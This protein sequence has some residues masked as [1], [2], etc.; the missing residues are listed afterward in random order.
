MHTDNH[1]Q[2]KTSEQPTQRNES[3][4]S[5]E[6]AVRLSVL[7]PENTTFGWES[8]SF[9][10]CV[11][12][13]KGQ[14]E[15]FLP[16]HGKSTIPAHSWFALSLD[17]WTANCRVTPGTKAL[18]LDCEESLWRKFVTEDDKLFHTHKACV[19]C[20]QRKETLFFAQAVRSSIQDILSRVEGIS[21]D[22]F[23][24]RLRLH[25][26]AVE[27]IAAVSESPSMNGAPQPEPCLRNEDEEALEAAARYLEDNL[28]DDHSLAEISRTVHLNEFKLKKGFKEYFQTT[29]FGY[30]RQKRMEYASRLLKHSK[31]TV[32]EAA[33]AVGYSNPSHFSR[34]FRNA[35]GVNPR[36]FLLT[37]KHGS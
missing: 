25:A 6:E 31:V 29:V 4:Y 37:S 27:L 3:D 33:Q 14:I 12:V 21:G 26:G 19:T 1:T 22:R 34:A 2:P 5:L 7:E 16:E 28:S 30:L 13:M 18:V 10:Q 9:M 35:F 24:D 36:E 32:I 17:G 15:L 23:S 11:F 20:S 8:E